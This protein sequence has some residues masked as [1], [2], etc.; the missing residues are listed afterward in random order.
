MSHCVTFVSAWLILCNV[1][2]LCRGPRFTYSLPI[3]AGEVASRL[4]C[5]SP[6]RGLQVLPWS[7]T[8]RCGLGHDTLI[9]QCLSP[10][11]CRNGYRLGIVPRWNCIPFGIR[12]RLMS[13]L[14][15]MQT[16]L[17][18][19]L[20]FIGETQII[21]WCSQSS[22]DTIMAWFMCVVLCQERLTRYTCNAVWALKNCFL[23]TTTTTTTIF[24]VLIRPK[25]K[26]QNRKK[27][28]IK[29]EY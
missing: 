24:I 8:L 29:L 23:I 2:G 1:N 17:L 22:I 4:V 9:S 7:G 6:D 21:K 27:L 13:H 16:S 28:R 20:P 11:R 12:S 25:K 15:H 14:A 5:S 26:L 3:C 18:Y 10:A 19:S